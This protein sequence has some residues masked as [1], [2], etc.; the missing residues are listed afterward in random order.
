MT[1]MATP[2][3][4][5]TRGTAAGGPAKKTAAVNYKSSTS[6]LEKPFMSVVDDRALSPN[7]ATN[8]LSDASHED[9]DVFDT[10]ET[11]AAAAAAVVSAAGGGATAGDF[12]ITCD[13]N[14]KTHTLTNSASCHLPWS[15]S[16]PEPSVL[17]IDTSSIA[18]ET[19]HTSAGAETDA[20]MAV[21]TPGGTSYVVMFGE[22]PKAPV[23]KRD[24]LT[25]IGGEAPK[26]PV[27]HFKPIKSKSFNLPK[28]KNA[29]DR[30]NERLTLK[31]PGGTGTAGA[32]TLAAP[33]SESHARD[34]MSVLTAQQMHAS[35]RSAY[36]PQ[37]FVSAEMDEGAT[38][39]IRIGRNCPRTVRN[40]VE[41]RAM[42]LKDFLIMKRIGYGKTS[43]VYKANFRPT[44]RVVAVKQYQ[45]KLLSP[46]NYRQLEREISIHAFLQHANILDLYFAFEDS[47]S[48]FLVMEYCECGD[49]FVALQQG[50]EVFPGAAKSS[51]SP[52]PT[53]EPSPLTETADSLM[54][55]FTGM[56]M[57]EEHIAVDIINPFVSALEYI[58]SVGVIHRDIKPENIFIAKDGTIKIGDFGLSIN[59]ARER[60][61]TR[62]ASGR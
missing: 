26:T 34:D 46:L 38:R 9:E 20:Q 54:H 23:K 55:R 39:T 61:S 33:S 12:Q 15:Q 41:A 60:P 50:Y 24:A 30:V 47:S 49:L 8:R 45:R 2:A 18:D 11:A 6:V 17:R 32:D 3:S 14:L 53:A 21:D 25:S 37:A 56:G 58:H 16:S 42:D 22:G 29:R 52:L 27:S 35:R 28:K 48:V 44:G 5:L 43:V 19:Q 40:V 1:I 62:K 59:T 4:R 31:S 51:S 7:V 13:E 57:L 36:I 10:D